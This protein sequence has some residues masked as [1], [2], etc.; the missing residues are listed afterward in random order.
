[1]VGKTISHYNVLAK[2][3]EGGM[4][5]VYKAEDTKLHRTVALKFLRP[6]AVGSH[7]LRSRFLTEAEAAAA[8]DH[9]NI[10]V[11]HEIDE[12]DGQTFI[13][14]AC[15]E[16]E[17]LAKKI[18]ERPLPI[19]VT[20]NIAAQIAEGLQT[21]HEGGV[22]HRDIK[23]A[24]IMVDPKGRVKVM[25]FG[26]AHL[27]QATRITR[28]GTVLGTPAYMSPEQVEGQ[29][30]DH[31]TDIWAFGVA[32]YEMLTGRVPFEAGSQ[33]AI[34]YA[35]VHREPEPLTGLRG[36]VPAELEHVI[37]KALAK[38]PADRYQSVDELKLDLG[39]VIASGSEGKP[40][41]SLADERRG[42]PW[43]AFAV[44]GL[45]LAVVVAAWWFYHREARVRWAR[46]EAIPR[47]EE[48]IER[49]ENVA[50]F[51][52]VREVEQ[53]FP[54]DP[55]LEELR[56]ICSRPVTVESDPPGAEVYLR[57]Y[58]D[59]DGPWEEM[60][61]T[62]IE[63]VRVPQ[64]YRHWRF[65][66]EGYVTTEITDRFI[67][68]AT[69][70]VAKRPPATVAVTLPRQ[71]SLPSGMVRI[72][73]GGAL[74]NSYSLPFVFTKLDGYLIDRY[75][76]TNG[77]YKAFVEAGG[78][79]DSQYWKLIPMEQVVS[80]FRD[81][82]GQLGPATW[83]L[84]TYPEGMEDHPVTGVSWYEAAAFAEFAG[85]RLPTIFH[86][87]RAASVWHGTL[88]VP[89]SNFGGE[90][91]SASGT[92]QGM[93]PHGVYDMAGNV[94]EWCW[95][96]TGDRRYI[97]GGAWS[98]EEYMF[99]NPD[100]RSPSD[101][102]AI[103]GFRCMQYEN[104]MEHPA[105]LASE[106]KIQRVDYG[107]EQPVSDEV[108][109]VYRRLLAYDQTE[110]N[111]Q[112]EEVD[113][114]AKYWIKEK[115]SFDA[116]YGDERVTAFLFRPKNASPPYQALVHFPGS[117]AFAKRSS[118]QMRIRGGVE[119]AIVRSGRV[120]LWP[121]YKGSFERA[122]PNTSFVAAAARGDMGFRDRAIMVVK[123]ARRSVDYLQSRPDIL[124]GQ[125]GFDGASL[126]VV[127]GIP[128]VGAEPRFR[129]ALFRNGGLTGFRTAAE[130]D[131]FHY[132]P[133]IR[134]PVLMLNGRFDSL[135]PLDTSQLPLLR[136]LGTPDNLKKHVLL[137][138]SHSRANVNA[139]I[140][141]TL[142]WL[143][144]HLGPAE[145]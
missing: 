35:I 109:E 127:M 16:G 108:F 123:D 11:V 104:A 129:I 134:V 136:M 57:R 75:E 113:E 131:P 70:D 67:D 3:G 62:P 91:S 98:E 30:T 20:L 78:Y 23:P 145:D 53:S 6:E 19:N 7:E 115:V 61:K 46:Y 34:M 40:G 126:G 93:S 2:I 88:S 44:A 21:A 14:M 130:V 120:L 66:K 132:L 18:S 15:L 114:S 144:R 17:S 69:P 90:G 42:R 68:L 110:L 124:S 87:Y 76:V 43:L 55:E 94:K 64:M 116:A 105:E 12:V 58:G 80:D 101:R 71:G 97:L 102:S 79:Q 128:V 73:S 139:E 106:V 22:I 27:D 81:R 45:L 74:L 13:V 135:F 122:D 133:R 72:P 100:A 26:L 83:E 95:N 41:K 140:R 38:D 89:L 28:T 8:L 118:D 86:W 36:G 119:G 48:L 54:E 31:R 4:G 37:T 138:R 141:E 47:I 60:G 9:P 49:Q 33:Q 25:D 5:V 77:K 59:L 137:E 85:K 65:T 111:A 29:K 56:A 50:A 125:I 10:C 51:Q 103:N 84:G 39:R 142:D 82:T 143:D 24:N 96:A 92:Y 32:L 99:G 63:N 1:M 112:V 121:V 52:L 107:R 117:W